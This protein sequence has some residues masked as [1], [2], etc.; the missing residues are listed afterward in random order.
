MT[1]ILITF[2]L[3]IL[4]QLTKMWSRNVLAFRGSIPVI[5]GFFHLSYVENRGAAFGILSGKT[6]LFLVV[7]IFAIVLLMYYARKQSS[8]DFSG[9]LNIAVTFI[10]AGALGNLIDRSMYGFVTDMIDFRGLWKF[11]FNVADCYV[12]CGTAALIFYILKFD[13]NK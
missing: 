1:Y 13:N 7:T 3:L 11:V 4:D 10:I 6:T 2:L 9:F 8:N 12:V 5:P